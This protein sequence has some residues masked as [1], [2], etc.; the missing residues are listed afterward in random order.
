MRVLRGPRITGARTS[1]SRAGEPA[2]PVAVEGNV[3]NHNQKKK[4]VLLYTLIPHPVPPQHLLM[5]PSGEGLE[6]EGEGLEEAEGGCLHVRE[7]GHQEPKAGAR[8]PLH[9]ERE[10]Q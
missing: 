6:G 1:S 5:E 2:N 4:G 8:L 9:L 3:L 7:S 10:E